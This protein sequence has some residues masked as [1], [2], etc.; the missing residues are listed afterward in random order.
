MWLL[1]CCCG[2]VVGIKLLLSCCCDYIV[3]E[4]L[5]CFCPY[6]VAVV[7]W[8]L[9]LCRCWCLDFIMLLWYCRT[10][11][12]ES[13]LVARLLQSEGPAHDS[14]QRGQGLEGG[15][16]VCGDAADG[17]VRP[18]V[19]GHHVGVE[20]VVAELDG[21]GGVTHEDTAVHLPVHPLGFP[22]GAPAMLTHRPT[23]RCVA[24]IGYRSIQLRQ[25]L[26]CAVGNTTGLGKTT[27]S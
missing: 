11:E 26:V 1:L 9:L 18:A 2:V 20:V 3:V 10:D 16:E 8:L 21:G 25:I 6:N 14:A 22:C 27:F 19:I 15:A 12:A 5:L 4:V 23:H 24:L 7:V 17:Y 13:V